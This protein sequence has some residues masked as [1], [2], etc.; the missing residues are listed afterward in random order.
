MACIEKQNWNVIII[1]ATKTISILFLLFGA[2]RSAK[3]LDKKQLKQI[4]YGRVD[5]ATTLREQYGKLFRYNC[6]ADG[7]R[8]E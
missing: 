3:V 6:L 5:P 1:I 2:Y 8:K 4:V 7:L